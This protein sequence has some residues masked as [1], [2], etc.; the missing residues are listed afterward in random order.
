MS[1]AD[2]LISRNPL[3]GR[4]GAPGAETRHPQIQHRR[5]VGR[6]V[7]V[8]RPGAPDHRAD[9]PSWDAVSAPR[10]DQRGR[11]PAAAPGGGG[12]P[13]LPGGAPA[14]APGG[15]D[16]AGDHPGPVGRAV[17]AVLARDT[18]LAMPRVPSPLE[19][20]YLGCASDLCQMVAD[21]T[22]RPVRPRSARPPAGRDG[23]VRLARRPGRLRQPERAVR[24]PPHGLRQ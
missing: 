14:L 22:S 9:R 21:G 7:P 15:A 20:A 17:I 2:F 23:L 10:Q 4:C 8:R 18:N 6:G 13:D 1:F 16:P 5:R 12:G 24:V 11:Q 19:I 3:A